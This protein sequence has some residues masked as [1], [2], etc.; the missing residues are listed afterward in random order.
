M[1][2]RKRNCVLL[3]VALAVAFGTPFAGTSVAGAVPTNKTVSLK[4]GF[5]GKFQIAVDSAGNVMT[6]RALSLKYQ[7]EYFTESGRRVNA[8]RRTFT[9]PEWA[10]VR[11]Y[12]VGDLHAG[13][14]SEGVFMRAVVSPFKEAATV[15]TT[16]ADGRV[17]GTKRLELGKRSGFTA[18][19]IEGLGGAIAYHAD[20]V[21]KLIRISAEGAVSEPIDVK[22]A[23]G[24]GLAGEVLKVALL[25]LGGYA[26]VIRNPQKQ[27]VVVRVSGL[28]IAGSNV[29]ISDAD[30]ET[31]SSGIKISANLSG[32]IAIYVFVNRDW[33]VR[34]IRSDD[35]VSVGKN[36]AAQDLAIGLLQGADG[37]AVSVATNAAKEKWT[38]VKTVIDRDGSQ[39]SRA[40]LSRKGKNAYWMAASSNASKLVVAWSETKSDRTKD[41]TVH[42]ANVMPDGSSSRPK[43][44]ATNPKGRK[45][46]P[47]WAT[48]VSVSQRGI[49]VVGWH[50]GVGPYRAFLGNGQFRFAR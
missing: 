25:P 37:S 4:G 10:P 20:G 43:I 34:L 27:I 45:G 22:T 28:G 9:K 3:W 30:P 41:T 44:L 8:M 15:D 31:D 24:T 32:Q 26:V 35:S 1:L 46:M 23:Q 40:Q 29:L 38:V 2:T 6:A 5:S 14:L 42:Y 49:A 12:F 13:A 17:I 21:V 18:A 39:V 48:T 50:N 36:G 7:V 16:R 33:T 19:S 11:K 47:K